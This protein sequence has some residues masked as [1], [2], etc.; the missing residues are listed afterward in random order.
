M[1][2]NQRGRAHVR[3]CCLL[4][5][6][7]FSAQIDGRH[8]PFPRHDLPATSTAV[9]A[10]TLL[11]DNSPAPS[12]TAF[13]ERQPDLRLRARAKKEEEEE[14]EEDEDDNSGKGKGEDKEEDEEEDQ[15]KE[16]AST[17]R[18]KSAAKDDDDDKDSETATKSSK[19]HKGAVVKST[20]TGGPTST[21]GLAQDEDD[22]DVD[23]DTPLPAPFDHA[24]S[25]DFKTTDGD[26]TC[27]RFINS[28]LANPSFRNCYPISMM[29]E[30]SNGLFD[31]K[32]RLVSMVRVLDATCTAD[33]AACATFMRQAAKDLVAEANCREE[34]KAG[35]S[36]VMQAW[37]GL[38]AYESIHA[39]SCL[40][41]R[42]TD[43]YC[44][45]NAVTNSTDRSDSYL[46]YLPF[47]YGLPGASN[48]SC[49]WCN[50]ETM[51]IFHATAADRGQLVADTY[52]NAARQVNTVCGTNFVNAT[53]PEEVESAARANGP[54]WTMPIFSILASA[55]L[56][57]I[58]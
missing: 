31:A 46:Y 20:S 24:R 45:A 48:P 52:E 41:D 16:S 43:S 18:S 23:D 33:S 42:N 9:P 35:V 22:K 44:Y 27:P 8:I 47:G 1:R 15:E 56:P 36:N 55:F 7:A 4:L 2:R 13:F 37:R 58:L 19:T 49:N 25:S 17:T 57:L 51:A 6:A 32:K 14:E 53:L 5:L 12:P 21:T 39:V 54:K 38:R 29:V 10:A 3:V 28:L 50:Q 30:T 11:V 40:H 34:F 26:D